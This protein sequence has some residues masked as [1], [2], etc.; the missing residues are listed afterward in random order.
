MPD[1]PNPRELIGGYATATLSREERE[2]LFTA[3]LED[4]ELFDEL[5]NEEPLIELLTD[6][7]ERQMLVDGLAEE[8][9]VRDRWFSFAA[10]RMPSLRPQYLALYGLGPLIL[11]AVVVAF[12]VR[13]PG[14][15]AP[16]L[17][18]AITEVQKQALN[19]RNAAID[20]R[21]ALAQRAQEQFRRG[22]WQ[23][24]LAT[25]AT[26][27]ELRKDD[28]ELQTILNAALAMAR[29][30]VA[31]E[32]DATTTIGPRILETN[33]FKAAVRKQESVEQLSRSG[34]TS[35]AIRN[36]WETVD[37][38]KLA[39]TEGRRLAQVESAVGRPVGPEQPPPATAPAPPSTPPPAPAPAPAPVPPAPPRPGPQTAP[40]P[41]TPPAPNPD[42]EQREIG[43]VLQMYAE[44]YSQLDPKAVQKV[45][46]G[47]NM[48]ELTA[49]FSQMQAQQVAI[50]D[51]RFV[52]LTDSTATVTC[53]WS[54]AFVGSVGGIQNMSTKTTIRLQQS[55]GLW[56]IVGR[57]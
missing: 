54:V 45:Y 22:E 27:F 42:A 6:P 34:Q 8:S 7:V 3:A 57:R 44:A 4:Q 56:M 47:V 16:A 53:T 13:R 14:P 31:A 46:P 35:D 25:V 17:P 1:Q 38:F 32:R 30:R 28:P 50:V 10:A 18:P 19:P 36:A 52:N 49:S 29:S 5:V 15:P 2:L 21:L 24:G 41:P 55:N 26:G 43:K 20:Q 23:N 37:L 33:A 9:P 39:Q 40:A 48:Q 11:V 51:V 12:V